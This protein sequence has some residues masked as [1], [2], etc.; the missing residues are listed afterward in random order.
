MKYVYLTVNFLE[1]HLVSITDASYFVAL[2]LSCNGNELL[3]LGHH[4][5]SIYSLP[6]IVSSSGN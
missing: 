2:G 3:A 4:G 1:A 6:Q 5:L